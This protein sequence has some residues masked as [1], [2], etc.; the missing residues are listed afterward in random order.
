MTE[1]GPTGPA[2]EKQDQELTETQLL[3]R[4]KPFLHQQ[5]RRFRRFGLS[6]EDLL[7]EASLAFIKSFRKWRPD[8]GANVLTWT[9]RPVVNAL[10]R[11]VESHDKHASNT[12]LYM[13]DDTSNHD[14]TYDG[15]SGVK[16][17]LHEFLGISIDEEDEDD[18][19]LR[20]R[21]KKAILSLQERERTIIRLSLEDRT[22]AEI[23]VTL[24]ISRERVRQLKAEAVETLK[25]KISRATHLRIVK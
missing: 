17:S 12:V 6:M 23:G 20:S 13:D 22:L 4:Y 10:T 5:A 18:P 24:G 7:Q 15:K 21:I 9:Y 8:G 19:L 14:T 16:T 25:A 3:E 2:V 1:K 11:V